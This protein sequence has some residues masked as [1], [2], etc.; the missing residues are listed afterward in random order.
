MQIIRAMSSHARSNLRHNMH[1]VAAVMARQDG[2]PIQRDEITVKEAAFALGFT[3][4]KN[5]L[6]KRAMFDGIMNVA[7]LSR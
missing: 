2:I 4:W 5:Y 3:F 7:R 6:E 1:K